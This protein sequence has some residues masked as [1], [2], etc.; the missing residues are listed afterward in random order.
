MWHEQGPLPP[1]PKSKLKFVLQLLPLLHRQVHLQSPS[2]HL[3]LPED[4][5]NYPEY[6]YAYPYT[7]A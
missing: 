4:T 3:Q 5:Y 2:K 7:A 1:S 6:T